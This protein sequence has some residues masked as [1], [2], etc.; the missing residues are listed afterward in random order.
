MSEEVDNLLDSLG[1]KYGYDR[2]FMDSMYVLVER[3]YALPEQYKSGLLMLLEETYK[4][5]MVIVKAAE[6][7]SD[8]KEWLSKVALRWMNTKPIKN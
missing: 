1:K 7:V 3:M 5:H 6:R 4:R 8:K 2:R